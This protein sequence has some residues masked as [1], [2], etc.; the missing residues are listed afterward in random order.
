MKTLQDGDARVV[1]IRDIIRRQR[2]HQPPDVERAYTR[3]ECIMNAAAAQE[4]RTP[5][6]ATAIVIGTIC[7]VIIAWIVVV[8][9]VVS[10]L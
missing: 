6:R 7:A 8:A 9:L 10:R 4:L 2:I 3:V 5:N 1:H